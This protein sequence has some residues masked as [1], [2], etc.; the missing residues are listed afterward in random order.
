MAQIGLFAWIHAHWE[1]IKT[2]LLYFEWIAGTLAA[3]GVPYATDIGAVLAKVL[4]RL[5]V[6]IQSPPKA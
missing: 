3:L 6:K 2:L 5:G 1:A 4:A